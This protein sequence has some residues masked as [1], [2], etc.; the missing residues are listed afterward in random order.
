MLLGT[1]VSFQNPSTGTTSPT[2][3]TVTEC[4]LTIVPP[5]STSMTNSHPSGFATGP[6]GLAALPLRATGLFQGL[7]KK[8]SQIWERLLWWVDVRRGR[9][10]LELSKCR[11]YMVHWKYFGVDGRGQLLLV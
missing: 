4:W 8:D 2:I 1:G 9:L 6:D 3:E 5:G 11:F 10:L 7:K